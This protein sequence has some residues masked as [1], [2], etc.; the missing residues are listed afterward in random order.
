MRTSWRLCWSPHLRIESC[1]F[2][3]TPRTCCFGHGFEPLE[4]AV[5]AAA[6]SG[7]H[8]HRIRL[9]R[10]LEVQQEQLPYVVPL[11]TLV[12]A[13]RQCPKKCAGHVINRVKSAHG[14]DAYVVVRKKTVVMYGEGLCFK[15]FS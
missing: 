9:N 2:F 14:M 3:S 10:S 15:D 5:Q 8:Y 4:V 12:S 13:L 11:L 6:P 1:V 7:S